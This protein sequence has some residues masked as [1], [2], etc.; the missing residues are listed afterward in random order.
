M[1]VLAI[2]NLMQHY[3]MMGALQLVLAFVFLFLLWR[4]IQAARC[5]RNGNCNS[6]SLPVWLTNLFK[7]KEE[8]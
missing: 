8:N 5:D 3:W 2:Q 4:N 6:C 1:F 7:K